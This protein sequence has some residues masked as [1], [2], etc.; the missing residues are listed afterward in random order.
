MIKWYGAKRADPPRVKTIQPDR[1][2]ASRGVQTWGGI[3]GSIR[4]DLTRL[5]NVAEDPRCWWSIGVVL[6][7]SEARYP[8]VPPADAAIGIHEAVATGGARSGG[9]GEVVLADR[10]AP[11]APGCRRTKPAGTSR[12]YRKMSSGVE[13][14]MVQC[15]SVTVDPK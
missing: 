1:W 3:P 8:R 11:T 15:P 6:R 2:Q 7:R 12:S 10:N 9:S 14:Q 4:A 13:R 5:R